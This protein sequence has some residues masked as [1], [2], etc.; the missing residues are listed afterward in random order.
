[1]V[2][3]SP[4]VFDYGNELVRELAPVL[5]QALLLLTLAT[6]SVIA[7]WRRSAWGLIGFWFF[8]ILAPTSSVLPVATQTISEHRMYLPLA[9]VI[10][11][12]VLAS[13]RWLG[14]RTWYI[15]AVVGLVWS[16]LT[17]QRNLDYRTTVGLWQDTVAKRPESWRAKNNLAL[18]LVTEE[19]HDE[20]FAQYNAALSLVPDSIEIRNNRASSLIALGRASAALHEI[21]AILVLAPSVAELHDTHGL[22]LAASGRTDAALAAYQEALRLKPELPDAYT[23]LGTLAFNRRKLSEALTYHDKALG[24]KPDFAEAHFNRGTALRA[25]GRTEEAKAAFQQALHWKQNWALARAQLAALGSM[26]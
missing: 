14:S 9:A 10:I 18:A 8:A 22:A 25:L 2:W 1:V 19:R 17:I 4:L 12:L 3:P 5:P 26:P 20:A 13:H 23:H 6:A 15:A 11:A 24:L 7:I 21:E 16:A